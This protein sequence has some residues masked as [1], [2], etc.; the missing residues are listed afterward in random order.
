MS[1]GEQEAVEELMDLTQQL[2]DSVAQGDWDTYTTLCDPTLTAIEPESLGAIVEGMDFHQFYFN[3]GASSG[4]YNATI[5]SPHVRLLG[6]TAIV[7]YVRLVQVVNA[8]GQP[9]SKR[10]EETRVWHRS[11][12][13]WRHVHFHRSAHVTG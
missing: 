12:E 2:L 10:F 9:V 11:A 4:P 8:A 6:D 1:N 3:L 13:G 5:C 7:S